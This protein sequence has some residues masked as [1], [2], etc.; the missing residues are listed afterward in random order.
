MRAKEFVPTSKPRNFVAKNQKTAGAGAHKDKKRAEKQGDVKHKAKQFEQGVAEAPDSKFVGF[1]N[2]TL[3]QKADAPA[4]KSSMP[5][6]M[7]DAPVAG[8]DTMG[9]KAALDFGMKTLN[10]LTPTQKT[11]L[12]TKGENGVVDWLENQAKKQGLL[13]TDD[14][15]DDQDE[16]PTKTPNGKFSWEDLDEVQDFL[17]DVFKDPAIK[18]W[19][20]VLTDGEPLPKA[21][22]V[23]PFSVSI[24]PGM[25]GSNGYANADWNDVDTL[26]NLPDAVELAKGLVQKNPKQ[27]VAISDAYDKPAGFYWPGKGWSGLKE[28]AV[29]DFLARGGEIQHGKF[30]KPRK[31]EKTDY[32]SK[33]IGG[34]RDAIAGK[35]GKTL[36]RAAATNFK[37][38]GKPV[39]GATYRSEG[40]A[41]ESAT[42]KLSGATPAPAP[43]PYLKDILMRHIDEVRHFV[44]TGYM[45]P[46]KPM[47]QELYEYFANE[48]PESVRRSPARLERRIGDMVAPY[49]KFYA[50]QKLMNGQGVAESVEFMS[51][52]Q[53]YGEL[54]S[55]L[56]AMG[57]GLATGAYLKARDIVKMYNA[58]RIMKALEGH[59]VSNISDAERRALTK[60]IAK[61]KQAMAERL[62][63]DALAIAKQIKNIATNQSSVS[64]A[65]SVAV[66][67]QRAADKQ[68]AK[69]DAS[70]ARTPSSIPKKDQEKKNG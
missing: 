5:D 54:L 4:D 45:D 66:R 49:A 69:S 13:V 52:A 38:G 17:S 39:V 25:P 28:D 34:Q 8:L 1:M 24:N 63:A 9:Y 29:D 51:D 56:A 33:H 42:K 31:S 57:A 26:E 11:K 58:D 60:L 65:T 46:T 30:R 23:G 27:F 61:F 53:F 36:G 35:A 7:K 40:V 14:D 37:G 16:N 21:P 22:V 18:S 43:N 32:G 70:L 19:A 47:F 50:D 59:R 41:E 12:S 64:E 68:R 10:K 44:N 48:I 67:M 2:K 15:T 20:L 6:F 62:G 55:V 3:G